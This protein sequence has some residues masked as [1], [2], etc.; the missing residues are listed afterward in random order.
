MLHWSNVLISNSFLSLLHVV[1]LCLFVLFLPLPLYTA[2]KN[3]DQMVGE[4]YEAVKEME[5]WAKEVYDYIKTKEFKE[6]V[7]QFKKDLET[8]IGQ[9]SFYTQP[10]VF[11]KYYPSYKPSRGYLSGDER[12]YIFIS[13]SMPEDTLRNLA[14]DASRIG[15]NVYLVMRGGINGLGKI[16]PTVLWIQNILKR[17]PIC[18]QNCEF[19]SVK[20]LIDPFLFRKYG[21]ERVPAVVYAAGI[22]N[23]SGLSEGLESVKTREYWLSYGDVP[24]SMHLKLIQQ[25]SGKKFSFTHLFEE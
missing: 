21:V 6:K 22:D 15:N 10:D 4:T 17:D 20:V 13:S 3:L 14:R 2:E 5:P 18:E 9:Q 16:T 19:Y 12:I 25:H 7:E 1:V 24:L 8:L 23:P 11:E